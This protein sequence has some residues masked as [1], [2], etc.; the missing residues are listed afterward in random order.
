MRKIIGGFLTLLTSTAS[1]VALA[2][3]GLPPTP[4]NQFLTNGRLGCIGDS[5]EGQ[6]VGYTTSPGPN[7][8]W[9]LGQSAAT[10]KNALGVCVYAE[11][12]S[13]GQFSVDINNVFG[14]PGQ[15]CQ[16]VYNRLN[17]DVAPR[18]PYFDIGV[19]SCG[20]NGTHSTMAQS[21]SDFGYIEKIAQWLKANGKVAVI[22]IPNPPR[23]NLTDS[24]AARAYENTLARTWPQSNGFNYD[25]YWVVTVDPTNT[26][27]NWISGDSADGLHCGPIGCRAMGLNLYQVMTGNVYP[28]PLRQAAWD[29]YDSAANNTGNL[30]GSS[31][32]GTSNSPQFLQGAGGHA[33]TFIT[34]TVP[35]GWDVN[36]LASGNS[37][38]AGASFTTASTTIT[39][40]GTNTISA[41]ANMG[42]YDQTTNSWVGVVSSWTSTTLTLKAA[43]LINSSGSAD[44]LV[45]TPM[46][47][48]ASSIVS[49]TVGS[50][51]YGSN[52]WCL[53]VSGVTNG[54]NGS[55]LIL[56]LTPYTGGSDYGV[57]DSNLAGHAVKMAYSVT[58]TAS[59]IGSSGGPLVYGYIRS[60][61]FTGHGYGQHQG[62]TMSVNNVREYVETSQGTF[63]PA[64]DWFQAAADF[65]TYSGTTD[66]LC[67]DSPRV[68][69]YN[70]PN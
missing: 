34:G 66:T 17:I 4:V 26:N 13:N 6:E 48:V 57:I 62:H 42:V 2:G 64:A 9:T 18:L 61:T 47:T 28:P 40:S 36:I 32:L 65:D 25:D 11:I 3:S 67:T 60:D 46:G 39:M 1:S 70:Q 8:Q 16:Y 19:I 27:G 37:L 55:P 56:E 20:R 30:I 38:A 50:G 43:S 52:Q 7:P 63:G 41:A 45:F 44:T 14:Y 29:I 35:E 69:M 31:Y 23:N 15:T 68:W 5:F 51:G 59:S 21:A 22:T 10:T 54:S 33:G 58:M 49:A 53:A 24:S 12:L